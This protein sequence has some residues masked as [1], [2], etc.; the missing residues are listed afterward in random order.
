MAAAIKL[1]CA[2]YLQPPSAMDRVAIAGIVAQV[3]GAPTDC[4]APSPTIATD[5]CEIEVRINED[6]DAIRTAEFPDGFLWSQFKLEMF[7]RPNKVVP[8]EIV[9]RLLNWFWSNGWSAVAACDFEDQL[10]SRGG[11]KDREAY[12]LRH[13]APSSA[14]S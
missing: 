5:D 10:P 7:A 14:A 2:I 9:S 13:S 6:F 1:D 4:S 3:L 11:Y 8:V 12:G